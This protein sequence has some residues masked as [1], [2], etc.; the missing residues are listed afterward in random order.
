MDFVAGV[1]VLAISIALGLA[2]VQ[3]LFWAIFSVM[4]PSSTAIPLETAGAQAPALD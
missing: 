4:A 3:A 1:V 2:S